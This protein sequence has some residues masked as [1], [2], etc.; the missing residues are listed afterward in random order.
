MTYV[1]SKRRIKKYILPIILRSRSPDQHYVEPFVGG[2]NMI[3]GVEGPRIGADSHEDIIVLHQAIQ[4]GYIPP[5]EITETHYALLKASPYTFPEKTF[6]GI[7]CSFGAKWFGGYARY[8][9]RNYAADGKRNLAKQAPSLAGVE[10]RHSRYQDL[11][12]PDNS[13]VYCDP[14]YQ[15]TLKYHKGID[16]DH[17]WEW[18]N[19]Q[20]RM[21]HTVFV[22]EHSAPHNWVEVWSKEVG[23]PLKSGNDRKAPRKE[24]LFQ[25]INQV[26]L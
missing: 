21:G 23:Q 16:H 17:F 10:F 19:T 3:D 8:R 6:A 22:S 20:V 24:R 15:D 7:C 4:G 9:G 25:H 5:D 13:I 14:P 26:F 12:I 11:V 1:G 18:C 2:G